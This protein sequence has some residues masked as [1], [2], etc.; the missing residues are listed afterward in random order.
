[1]ALSFFWTCD[2]FQPMPIILK[3]HGFLVPASVVGA[4][5]SLAGSLPS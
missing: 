1:M 3:D 4:R 2:Y 5:L